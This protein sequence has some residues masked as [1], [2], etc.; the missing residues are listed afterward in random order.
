MSENVK[1]IF[2]LPHQ[3]EFIKSKAMHTAIVGGYGSGKTEGGLYKIF[4]VMLRNRVDTGYYL[5]TYGLV[6][7]VAIKKAPIVLKRMGIDY[8][9]KMKPY[10]LTLK[11]FGTMMLRSME[12]PDYIAGYEVGYSIIDE[13]DRMSKKKAE[14]AFNAITARNRALMEFD[15]N[16]IDFVCTPEGYS[17]LYD[18]F[19]TKKSPNKKLIKA[20]TSDNPFLPSDYIDQL[21]ENYTP[22]QLEAY[23]NGEFV[24]MTTG[25]VYRDYNKEKNYSP[26]EILHNDLL[27]VGVDFNMG[28]MSAVVHVVDGLTATAVAEVSNS[29]DTRSLAEELKYRYP[30]HRIVIY[31]DASGSNRKTSA[32]KTD[33][34]ILKRYGFTVK[35]LT[36]NPFV[37]DRIN[38]MNNAFEKMLYFVNH[39]NCPSYSE[40]LQQ[41]P[42][43]GNE[44]DKTKGL[45]HLPDAGGYFVWWMFGK[46]KKT[47]KF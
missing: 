15:K 43:K 8:S 46:G 29:Y 30:R 47:T 36:R 17:F 32:S 21:R 28:N 19:V 38:T 26:R 12:K 14:E 27:H 39:M 4:S 22:E 20:K 9:I 23:L 45:D 35:N 40:C 44:P 6:E 10:N 33:V 7:D 37:K 13:I 16:S 1:K 34:Q 25:S 2:L 5:P 18:F 31:P 41:L 42:Y 3:K 11:G 24:N